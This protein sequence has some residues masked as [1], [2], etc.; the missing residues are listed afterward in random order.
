M[1][2]VPKK[3]SANLLGPYQRFEFGLYQ[4]FE[5]GLYQ[6]FEFGPYLLNL[7]PTQ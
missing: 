3:S 6:R 1:T 2:G 5:F 4:R 7:G